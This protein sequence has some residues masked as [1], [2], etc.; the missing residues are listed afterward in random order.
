[1]S[2]TTPSGQPFQK[3][4]NFRDIANSINTHLPQ[5]LLKPGLLYRSAIPDD[6]TPQ[7]R[8]ILKDHYNLKTIIDLRTDSE[9]VEQTRKLAKKIPK[10]PLA[11]PKDPG[12]ALRI[13]G[14]EYRCI[15]LNG[16]AY[17]SALIKQLS[18]WN[19]A[20]L[21][22]LYVVGY[23][24]DAIRVLGENV[25]AKRGLIGLAEDSLKHSLSEVK[26]VFDVLSEERNYPLMVHC[27]QGKDRTGLVVL[28]VLLLLDVPREA[29]DRDYML[30]E[31]ELASEREERMVQI[32]AIGLPDD[33][34]GCAQGWVDAVSKCI[35]EEYGGIEKYLGRCGITKGQMQRI[36]EIMK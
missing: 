14:V 15:S 9:H 32:R 4:L 10:S 17:S 2:T 7:D 29:I 1:M 36:R 28:L 3:L 27:T 22:G 13:P 26:S 25:M 18:Y 19:T 30:S 34:A 33:F 31:K 23:R 16:H 24:T 35:D 5:P 11:E 6:A 8:T 12:A 21:C 20:K